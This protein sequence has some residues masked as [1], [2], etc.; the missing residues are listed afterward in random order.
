MRSPFQRSHAMRGKGFF[1]PEVLTGLC[2]GDGGIPTEWFGIT[3]WQVA[4]E[5]W[6]GWVENLL[7]KAFARID[8]GK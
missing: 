6:K 5:G 8:F 4:K 2:L 1:R 7:R 3:N